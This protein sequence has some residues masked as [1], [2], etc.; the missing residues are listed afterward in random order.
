MTYSNKLKFIID[1]VIVFGTYDGSSEYH[2]ELSKDEKIVV[3][4]KA[5]TVSFYMF[6]EELAQAHFTASQFTEDQ[7][8]VIGIFADNCL[9]RLPESTTIPDNMSD[10]IKEATTEAHKDWSGVC[11]VR[12]KNNGSGV[13][14]TVT[15]IPVTGTCL[16]VVSGY[17]TKSSYL[18]R[19]CTGEF[20]DLSDPIYE[21][22]FNR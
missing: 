7:E 17:V 4:H 6:N 13:T 20:Y 11:I 18:I 12:D 15:Q 8:S 21:R 22:L 19:F 16:F 10:K 2:Y 9:S 14:Y 3:D 1:Y 5:E